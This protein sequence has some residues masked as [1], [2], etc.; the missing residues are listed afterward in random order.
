MW[1][2][3]RDKKFESSSDLHFLAEISDQCQWKLRQESHAL[4]TKENDNQLDFSLAF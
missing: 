1:I 4:A 3:V 2:K